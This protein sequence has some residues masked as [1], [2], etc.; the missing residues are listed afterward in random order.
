MSLY[1]YEHI[2]VNIRAISVSSLILQMQNKNWDF[3]FEFFLKKFQKVNIYK[4]IENALFEIVV[5]KEK[6][7]EASKTII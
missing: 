5:L 6:K 3:T 1:I 7:S 4:F 2:Q